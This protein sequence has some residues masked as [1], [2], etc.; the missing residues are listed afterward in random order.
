MSSAP[1]AFLP[2]RTEASKCI[3][4]IQYPLGRRPLTTTLQALNTSLLSPESGMLPRQHRWLNFVITFNG[5][6]QKRICEV[7]QPLFG[8]DTGGLV[9]RLRVQQ[10]PA[11]SQRGCTAARGDVT[12]P[13]RVGRRST[14]HRWSAS[15]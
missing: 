5:E 6:A 8:F 12:A 9:L 15:F 13:A 10:R 4:P 11:W 3:V 2:P 7:S 14:D 1:I